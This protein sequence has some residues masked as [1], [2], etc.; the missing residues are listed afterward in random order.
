[1]HH[2]HWSVKGP[3]AAIRARGSGYL[4]AEVETIALVDLGHDG[5]EVDHAWDLAGLCLLVVVDPCDPLQVMEEIVDRPV[6]IRPFDP[7]HEIPP[8]LFGDVA[9]VVQIDPRHNFPRTGVH[10]FVTPTL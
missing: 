1:M 9:V 2:T 10:L 4:V 8:L 3:S 7:E 5:V 6:P